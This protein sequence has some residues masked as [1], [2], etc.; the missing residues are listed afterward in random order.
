MY[1]VMDF[2]PPEL[3]ELKTNFGP[4]ENREDAVDYAYAYLAAQGYVYTKDYGETL[5]IYLNNHEICI[6]EVVPPKEL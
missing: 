2:A 3:D 1:I 6:E 5:E 4:F